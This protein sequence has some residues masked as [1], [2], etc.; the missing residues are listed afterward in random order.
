[1]LAR[2]GRLAIPATGMAFHYYHKQAKS[3]Q[4]DQL[5][6]IKDLGF[7]V[8]QTEESPVAPGSPPGPLD[9]VIAWNHIEIGKDKYD[10]GFLDRLVE[11]CEAVG[12]KLFHD[13]ELVHHLPTWVA[14]QYP[15]TEIVA[16]TGEKLGFYHR[17][18]CYADYH[19]RCYSLAHDAC[20]AAAADFMGKVS[21]R[22]AAS[23][24]VVGYILFEEIGLN[25]P[26]AL[27][28][29]G[30]DVGPATVAGFEQYL[31]QKYGTLSELNRRYERKYASFGAAANDRTIFDQHHKP[32]RGWMDWC[33]YRSWYVAR[34]F[35]EVRDAVKQSDPESLVVASGIDAYAAYWIAQGF[36]AE[37]FGFVDMLAEKPCCSASQSVRT[38]NSFAW[39]R[40]GRTEVG[41][42]NLN[43]FTPNIPVWDLARRAFLL[44]GL[45]SRWT[46]LYAWHWYSHEDPKTGKRVLHD[47]LRGFLPYV[48]WIREHREFLGG[49][50]PAPAEV[51]I[52]KPVRSDLIEFWHNHD[53]RNLRRSHPGP[54]M[55]TTH[56]SNHIQD[57]LSEENVPFDIVTEEHLADALHPGRYRMLIVCDA[58]LTEETAARIRTW[59]DQGGKLLLM[60]GAGRFDE[61]G[62]AREY[63]QD[64]IRHHNF[65]SSMYRDFEGWEKDG[66]FPKG[67]KAILT[68]QISAI[69][70]PFLLTW[71]GVTRPLDFEAPPP[72]SLCEV[73]TAMDPAPCSPWRSRIN[74]YD[75]V[76][77]KG[78]AAFILVQRNAD[79]GLLKNVPVLWSG[80]PVR[81]LRPPSAR[82]VRA[83]P[84]KGKLVLP[85]WSDVLIMVPV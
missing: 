78:R 55:L 77:D 51:A 63:F 21:Q 52:L 81:V 1:M 67:A 62:N 23:S 40:S 68:E 79:Q 15:D 11:D 13:I 41:A 75:M 59:V 8:I 80:G 9:P 18:F 3:S 42:S 12:L 82:S 66:E 19:M 35:H 4:R 46:S 33:Y 71:A 56:G 70:L 76:D 48:G 64:I 58:H 61:D 25:Y 2:L 26:H 17:P 54:G 49:L 50:K 6:Q 30:Q 47:N 10:W 38:R 84:S 65:L 83:V 72:P 53:P 34:F 39:M 44:I 37:E 14:R 74:V 24:A 43:D 45:G 5:R 69:Q 16:P 22:Y 31:K 28:W 60:P 7:D 36:R 85:A 27:T 32:H 29:Y 20:R 57:L 73:G